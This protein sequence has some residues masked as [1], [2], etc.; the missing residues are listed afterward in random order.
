MWGRSGCGWAVLRGLSR[1]YFLG[2]RPAGRNLHGSRGVSLVARARCRCAL[3]RGRG[4]SQMRLLR[5]MGQCCSLVGGRCRSRRS[6]LFRCLCDRSMLDFSGWRGRWCT[7]RLGWSSLS[8]RDRPGRGDWGAALRLVR[9]GGMRGGHSGRSLVRRGQEVLIL[10]PS[11]RPRSGCVSR[12]CWS[13]SKLWLRH[14]D[15]RHCRWAALLWDGWQLLLGLGRRRL[16]RGRGSLLDGGSKCM[17]LWGWC[18]RGVVL[19]LGMHG[20][21]GRC[22]G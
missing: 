22:Y 1:C 6:V 21:D 8:G 11:H 15:G 16:R 4:G 7:Q 14:A 13:R 20:A 18:R 12:W 2:E 17:L 9:H 3:N 19:S 10:I 5:D